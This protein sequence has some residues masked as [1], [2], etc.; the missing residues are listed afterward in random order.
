M[1]G[2]EFSMLSFG[3]EDR[4]VQLGKSGQGG[5]PWRMTANRRVAD[6][7]RAVIVRMTVKAMPTWTNVNVWLLQYSS[8]VMSCYKSTILLCADQG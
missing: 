2:P 1:T 8:T 3:S 5:I 6:M 4:C 7:E